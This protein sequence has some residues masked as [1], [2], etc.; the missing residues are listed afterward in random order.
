MWAYGLF[1]AVSTSPP[2]KPNPNKDLDDIFEI[3]ARGPRHVFN[4][5]NICIGCGNTPKKIIA[6]R[7]GCAEKEMEPFDHII[8]E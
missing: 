7:L 3:A 1:V 6:N 2:P 8:E 4:I 5:Q